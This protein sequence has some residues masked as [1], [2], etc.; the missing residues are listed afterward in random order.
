MPEICFEK[1]QAYP[2][3]VLHVLS[4]NK[5][6]K[7]KEHVLYFKLKKRKEKKKERKEKK[8]K[9]KE[10]KKKQRKKVGLY[11]RWM[12]NDEWIQKG[13]LNSLKIGSCE[14]QRK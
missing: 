5:R 11:G 2:A 4:F 1:C 12:M 6:K 10:K 7:R 9:R 14:V 13:S 3:L 8:K